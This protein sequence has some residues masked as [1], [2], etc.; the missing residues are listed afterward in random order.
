MMDGVDNL[1]L[2]ITES[3]QLFN[4]LS[5]YANITEFKSGEGLKSFKAVV[6]LPAIP[7]I[8][9]KPDNETFHINTLV[10]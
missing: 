10:T 9:V 8:L 1:N 3:G 5:S 2:D 4:A 6:H 7:R